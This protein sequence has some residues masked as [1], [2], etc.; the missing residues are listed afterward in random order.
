MKINKHALTFGLIT[1]FLTG[2]GFTIIS[3][4]V[5]FMVA[6]FAN[7]HDQALI[8]TSLMAI[9]ALCTFFAAPA[10][11]SLSD[12]FGRKPILLI[13]LA[14]SALGYLIF[15]LAGS[16]WMLFLG[17]I[18]DGLTGGNIVALFAYFAD[19][20]DEE[21][22]TKVFGWTAAAVGV[23]TISGPTVGGLLAHFGNS[24]PFYFGALI[25]IA[26]LLYGAFVMN[27]SLPETHRTRNFSLKQLNPFTQLFQLLRMK[28]LNRLLFSG[29]L[30]WL[31]NGA[32]QAII[33]QFSL[34]SFA[35]T[36][37]LIGLAISIMGLMDILTQIFIMP[38]LLK[39]ANED[40]LIRLA[41]VCEIIAYL[42]F[43]LSAFSKMWPFFI[44]AMFTFAFGDSIFGTAFNGKLSKSATSSEQGKLQGGSQA[45]QALTRVI[46]PLIGGQIYISLGHFAP[47][48]MGFIFLIIA[49]LVLS[50]TKS[51]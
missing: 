11:G 7:A 18:I 16:L 38:R 5:P 40:K 1:T 30:L 45:L 37:V 26:N 19:I 29:I 28:N 8:V 3:P 41:L 34:D 6:P 48:L 22:R 24:V 47:A 27:E 23:G 10:L 25:S 21:N 14:G 51:D 32:L 4:V 46:G 43:A 44:L 36:P 15:G 20:T 13:S 17:R 9:Y 35:W 33:S 42:L 12:R 2:L 31:P 50:K 49:L 39:L